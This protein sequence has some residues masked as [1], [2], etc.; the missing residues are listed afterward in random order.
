MVGIEGAERAVKTRNGGVH[1]HFDD[2]TYLV[3]SYGMRLC[4]A[5]LVTV[6]VEIIEM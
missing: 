1:T 6:R 4:V 2:S 3:D 5:A